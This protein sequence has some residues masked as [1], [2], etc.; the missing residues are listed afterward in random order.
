M[1]VKKPYKKKKGKERGRSSHQLGHG[2]SASCHPL[3]SVKTF[4]GADSH[5]LESFETC[6]HRQILET[7]GS[8]A[9][10]DHEQNDLGSCALSTVMVMTQT[11]YPS[12]RP[13]SLLPNANSYRHI[14]SKQHKALSSPPKELIVV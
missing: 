6:A 9:I 12:I 10:N 8:V 3:T 7:V 2:C 11:M 5:R 1:R 4:A 13:F 14:Q